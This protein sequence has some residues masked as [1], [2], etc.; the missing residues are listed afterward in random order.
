[1]SSSEKG[2]N[3]NETRD[4][5]KTVNIWDSGPLGLATRPPLSIQM[6]Q[7]LHKCRETSFIWVISPKTDQ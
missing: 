5:T 6:N 3:E 1:M 7:I 4:V 2:L